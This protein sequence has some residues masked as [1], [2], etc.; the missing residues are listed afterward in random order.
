VSEASHIDL[1]EEVAHVARRFG[2]CLRRAAD[3]GSIRPADPGIRR[4]NIAVVLPYFLVEALPF[5]ED[6]RASRTMAVANALGAAHFLLQDRLIDGDETLSPAALELSDRLLVGFVREYGALSGLGEGFWGDFSRYLAQYSRSLS[7]EIEVLR[8]PRGRVAV[9]ED[10]IPRTLKRL[11]HRMAL[12]KTS[13]A[14]A[15]RLAGRPGALEPIERF[16]DS[17]HAGYQLADDLEDLEEDLAR[18]RWSVVAWII[19]RA[20]GEAEPSALGDPRGAYAAAAACGAL[21]SVTRLI[22]REYERAYEAARS[23]GSP[24]LVGFMQRLIGRSSWELARLERRLR[25]AVGPPPPPAA[26]G[27]AAGDPGRVGVGEGP[28]L[29]A[30]T[31]PAVPASATG[32]RSSAGGGLLD[33]IHQFRVGEEGYVYDIASGLLFEADPLATSLIGWLESGAEPVDL[34][35]LEMNHGAEQVRDGLAEMALFAG[36]TGGAPG[37]LRAP[38]EGAQGVRLSSLAL[39]L[40]HRCNLCCDYCYLPR[41]G[42]DAATMSEETA[43]RAVDLLLEESI[44]EPAVSIVFFGG[45]PLLCPG[46]IERVVEHATT[47][48]GSRRRVAF[49][50]T[51]NGT[52]LSPAVAAGLTG[53]GVRILVSIDGPAPDHDRHRVFPDGRGSYRQVAARLTGLPPGTR[54][55]ARATVTPESSRLRDIVAHLSELGC[56]MIHLAPVSGGDM[57]PGFARRLVSEYEELARD[58]LRRLK[59]GKRPRVGNFLEAMASLETGRLRS[60]PCGAGSRYLSVGA[61]GALFLCHRFGGDD[62]HLVGD[63]SRGIDRR[64]VRLLLGRFGAW[65]RRCEPCWARWLCGGPCYYDLRE[66]SSLSA[67]PAAPRCVVRTRILELAMWLYASLPPKDRERVLGASRGGSG[68]GAPADRDG[69]SDA[70]RAAGLVRT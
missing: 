20:A 47:A 67:G 24:S 35:V 23:L 2:D 60:L 5:Q 54:V 66:G 3:A 68:D 51:T 31:C 69:A 17:F 14:A 8:T 63:V 36:A 49:H 65:R 55:G 43:L 12:L 45:E 34:R 38:E 11:G 58:E 32:A 48:G 16:V 59:A 4:D 25:L 33:G 27:I 30:T 42:S 1:D 10:S 39:H 29:D 61:D 19:T 62:A 64:R 70:V 44:G 56:S 37:P 40:T 57:T 41:G 53:M 46:L 9:S 26:S 21:Q 13:G 22:L 50:V 6:V 52:L 18:G 28:P 15:T 7:W